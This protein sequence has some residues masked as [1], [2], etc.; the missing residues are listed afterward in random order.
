MAK[1]L[2]RRRR[3]VGAAVEW[4]GARFELPSPVVGEGPEYYPLVNLW[5]EQ[6]E[7]VVL[8]AELARPSECE[9]K[10]GDA[11]IEAMRAPLVG[12]PR[13][14]RRLRVAD[15]ELAAEVTDSLRE[16]AANIPVI[17]APTPE[18]EEVREAMNSDLDATVPASY[19][20]GDG[21]DEAGVCLLFEAA[22]RLYACAPWTWLD[23]ALIRID[24]P[25]LGVGAAAVS[26]IGQMEESPGFIVYSSVDDYEEFTGMGSDAIPTLLALGYESSSRLP[27]RMVG[28]A[29]FHGWE[30]PALD[31][32]P[33][34]ISMVEGERVAVSGANLRVLASCAMGLVAFCT[35]FRDELEQEEFEPICASF[36]DADGVS[37]RF[38]A[39][40]WADD[41]FEISD[42]T[43]P[44]PRREAPRVGRNDP[45]PCG[46]GKK[47]KKCHLDADTRRQ[48][49]SPSS[50]VSP[51]PSPSLSLLD[52]D[53]RLAGTIARWAGRAFGAE[54][55]E[56]KTPFADPE[57]AWELFAQWTVY[58]QGLRQRP[59]VDH[60][61]EERGDRLSAEDR[62]WLASQKRAWL[63]VWEAESID[64][65]VGMRMRD[66]LTGEVRDVVEASASRMLVVRASLLG[67]VVDHAG[68]SVLCGIHPFPLPPRESAEVVA[69]ARKRLRRKSA[70]PVDRLRD[71][72]F[73][74]R[75]IGDWEDVCGVYRDR[76]FVPPTVQ[77]T[78]GDPL[79][80]TTD[81]FEFD[82]QARR[83]IEAALAGIDGVVSPGAGDPPGAYSFTRKGNAVHSGWE[84]TTVAFV[85]VADGRLTAETDSIQRADAIR[86]CLEDTC[87]DLLRHR[88]REHTDPSSA[89]D[90]ARGDGGV[91]DENDPE[92]QRLG[93]LFKEQHYAAWPDQPLPALGGETPRRA[94]RTAA[95][96]EQVSLLLKDLEH[97]EGKLPE[98]ERFDTNILRRKLGMAVRS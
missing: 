96:R 23:D 87:G 90:A 61:L 9:G 38:T 84:S 29:E 92:L 4:V 85:R 12:V 32:Y 64:P 15:R 77:N 67:R 30:I 58:I 39:P 24:I 7:G 71:S 98:A 68:V 27:P 78:D 95:G 33:L 43:P 56:A 79:L 72:A 89:A 59:V 25:A 91:A 55:M 63:S 70:V 6:P 5:I 73:A 14:P 97:F 17:V 11:L 18:A 44:V 36:T 54:W 22:S 86:V 2:K 47:Y 57:V 74:G 19:L 65:G 20:E 37:V 3:K 80:L 13:R 48:V 46:S 35:K 60:F 82:R 66:L 76:E 53:Q 51:S 16:V 42:P 34:L 40:Y 69:R 81:H 41:Q 75:L 10:L 28:E 83:R 50:F 62:D 88:A 49:P 31:T 26:V 93:R 8:A 21:V 94:V 1:K 45:C 52:R